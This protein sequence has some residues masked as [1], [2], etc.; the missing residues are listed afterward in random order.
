MSKIVM[1]VRT[2]KRDSVFDETYYSRLRQ[3][4]ELHIYDRPDFSDRDYVL[5]FVSGAEVLITSWGT[6]A[7]DQ[8][9]LDLCP[10]LKLVLHAAG[11]VKPVISD[12][13]LARNI[14][15]TNSAVAIGE[16]VA[17]TAL[18]LAITACKGI[19]PLSRDTRSGLWAE[20]RDTVVKDFYG[21]TVGVIG[22][23]F[24]GRHFISLL[25]NFHVDILLYDPTLSSEQVRS[26]GAE[27]AELDEL[28]R[29]SDAISIHA[30]SIPATDNMLNKDNLPLIKDG[31]VLINTARGSI[32]EETALIEELKKGRF[33]ACIDVTN[34]EPPAVDNE[35]RKLDNVILTPHLAGT[36]TTGRKRIAKHICEELERFETGKPLRTGVDLSQLNKLA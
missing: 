9:I 6:P 20:N 27:K 5:S 35:L 18:G 34:P 26:L 22:G 28:L 29:R 36:V 17:E 3:W 32:I 33:F 10:N 15:I 24:V 2:D 8:E 1:L 4:G 7:L 23:G 21:I 19:Y 25:H 16:G 11:T 12:A 30:P 14:P 13:F 31:A